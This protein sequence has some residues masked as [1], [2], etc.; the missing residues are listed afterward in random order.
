L[1]D[2]ESAAAALATPSINFKL[3]RLNTFVDIAKAG[4]FKD[5]PKIFLN[6]YLKKKRKKKR[7]LRT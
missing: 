2:A 7:N 1:L 5:L 6:N 4:G 3:I